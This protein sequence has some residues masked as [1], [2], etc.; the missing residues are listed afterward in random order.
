MYHHIFPDNCK[1]MKILREHDVVN[2]HA[3]RPATFERHMRM[4]RNSGLWVAPMSVVARYIDERKQARI[5][6]HESERSCLIR[7]EGV[8]LSPLIQV[9][10]TLKATLPWNWARV[11]GSLHDGIY[12]VRDGQILIEVKPDREIL[13]E[14]LDE[15]VQKTKENHREDSLPQAR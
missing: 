8:R 10:L 2:T 1:E 11:T 9:P 4:I 6:L 12:Q 15:R 13:I 14:R 3:V 7:I 5:A